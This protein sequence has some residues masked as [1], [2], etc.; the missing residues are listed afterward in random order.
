MVTFF[1]YDAR[2]QPIDKPFPMDGSAA[3]GFAISLVCDGLNQTQDVN[4][5]PVVTSNG[6]VGTA[7][8]YGDVIRKPAS[9]RIN[10]LAGAAQVQIA[11]RGTNKSVWVRVRDLAVSDGEIS[12][13]Y[14]INPINKPKFTID[15][16]TGA[17]AVDGADYFYG[18]CR[19]TSQAT[20]QKF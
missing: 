1:D 14:R 3:K 9:F 13:R 8:T 12:G 17:I 5:T 18:I 6:S 2:H 11:Q 10:V 16:R 19:S 7:I 4:L 15:R 20:T